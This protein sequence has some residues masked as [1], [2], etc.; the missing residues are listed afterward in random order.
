M[1]LMILAACR[2]QNGVNSR[3]AKVNRASRQM[4]SNSC[5]LVQEIVLLRLPEA[6]ANRPVGVAV[7]DWCIEARR[8]HDAGAYLADFLI[9]EEAP[10]KG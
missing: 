1:A 4:V 5:E 6:V 8:L 10:P 9:G 3:R 2:I 7:P